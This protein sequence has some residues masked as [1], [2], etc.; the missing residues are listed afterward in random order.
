MITVVVTVVASGPVVTAD[1]VQ[2]PGYELGVADVSGTRIA[3]VRVRETAEH[4]EGARRA[5]GERV[6]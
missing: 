5:S 6:R 3:R 1:T 4:D 2:V